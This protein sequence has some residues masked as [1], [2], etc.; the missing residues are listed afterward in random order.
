MMVTARGMEES[1][2]PLKKEPSNGL[3][4]NQGEQQR[5]E[6][7]QALTLLITP[8]S[9][10]TRLQKKGHYSVISPVNTST[11]GPVM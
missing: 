10:N 9:Q 5:R 3:G 6:R 7:T 1:P 11:A 2:Y 4:E 8:S